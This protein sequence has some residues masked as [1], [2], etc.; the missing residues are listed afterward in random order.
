MGPD[1]TRPR[2]KHSKSLKYLRDFLKSAGKT[3]SAATWH[4]YYINGRT[5]VLENFTDPNVLDLLKTEIQ[6][7]LRVVR[8]SPV[9]KVWLGETGSAWGGGARHLSDS[10]VAGFM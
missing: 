8:R 6:R 2:G 1:V 4:Q 5:A 10:Y 9:E 7:V 3:I